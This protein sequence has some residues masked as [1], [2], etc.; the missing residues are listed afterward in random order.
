M[1]GLILPFSKAK[2][3][4]EDKIADEKTDNKD[5]YFKGQHASEELV[6]F[7]RKHWVNALPHIGFLLLFIAVEV[8]FFISFAKISGLVRGNIAIELLFVGIVILATIYMHK[9]Y[10][11]MFSYFMNTV[12]F[13]STRIVESKKTLFMQDSHEVLD[14]VKIQDVRKSQ[15]GIAK[16]LLR[17]GDLLITLSSSQASKLLTYVPN[18]NFHFRCLARIK[19]D[20]FQRGRLQSIDKDT[21]PDDVVN[22]KAVETEFSVQEVTKDILKDAKPNE[23]LEVSTDRKRG[24]LEKEPTNSESINTRVLSY[25]DLVLPTDQEKTL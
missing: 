8:I 2:Q 1:I 18:V 17:Y 16:N 12:I 23:L 25:T 4:V 14:T 9:I 24:Y 5:R 3:K 20:A 22:L 11:R 21:K 10:M 6:C 7:F 15:N 19:R 13:T